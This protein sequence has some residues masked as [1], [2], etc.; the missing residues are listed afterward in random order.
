MNPTSEELKTAFDK[1]GIT[2]N[3]VCTAL[4]FHGAGDSKWDWLP[5][6]AAIMI[7]TMQAKIDRLTARLH[8]A[9][10]N[11]AQIDESHLEWYWAKYLPVQPASAHEDGRAP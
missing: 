2:G 5:Q 3:D 6:E 1:G 11:L 4:R 7:E 10:I 8:D 9:E